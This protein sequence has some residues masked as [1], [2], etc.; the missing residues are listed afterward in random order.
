MSFASPAPIRIEIRPSRT[1]RTW[2]VIARDAVRELRQYRART[3]AGAFAVASAW[4]HG[5]TTEER[6]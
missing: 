4:A 2:G 1:G 6:T 5:L 3:R